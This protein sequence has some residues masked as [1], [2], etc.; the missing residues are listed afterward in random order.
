MFVSNDRLH[1]RCVS[2]FLR[3]D[4][5]FV[6]GPDLK[7]NLGQI[8]EYYLGL[9]DGTREE[10]VYSFADEPPAVGNQA[11]RDLWTR[12][13]PKWQDADTEHLDATHPRAPTVDEIRKLAESPEMMTSPGDRV[14]GELD[15]LVIKRSIKGKKGS[16]YQGASEVKARRVCLV[17][18][19]ASRSLR[20][21]RS[22]CPTPNT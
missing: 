7:A 21:S 20:G 10:G 5:E 11:V 18:C 15:Q 22:S 6:W 12:L 19:R 1:Q 8:N 4:Q 16:W 9:P 3:S 14:S 2:L 13:L 17:S